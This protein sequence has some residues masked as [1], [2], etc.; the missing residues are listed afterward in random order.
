MLQQLQT[1]QAGL[2]SAEATQRLARYGANL[3]KPHK[4]SDVWTLLLAQFKSP[5]LIILVFATGLSL[6]LR[7]PADAC[8]ILPLSL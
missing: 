1:T 4:R 6:F 2:T 7:D 8:I 3:L 5:I